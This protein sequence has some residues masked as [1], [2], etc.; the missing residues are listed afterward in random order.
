MIGIDFKLFI[1][2]LTQRK[3]ERNNLY[4]FDKYWQKSNFVQEFVLD[5]YYC[6]NVNPST[7]SLIEVL[8]QVFKNDDITKKF[9][10]IT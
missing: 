8:V 10:L 4:Q 6:V 5:V 1:V 9:I 3:K 2:L 7:H